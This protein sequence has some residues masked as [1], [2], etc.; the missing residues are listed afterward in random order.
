MF[1]Q[2]SETLKFENNPSALPLPQVVLLHFIE[3]SHVVYGNK[4]QLLRQKNSK[5]ISGGHPQYKGETK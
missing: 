2:E 3:L 5:N 4:S 1:K